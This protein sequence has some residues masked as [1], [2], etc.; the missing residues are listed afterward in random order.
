MVFTNTRPDSVE[1]NEEGGQ[2]HNFL[3]FDTAEDMVR[4][5]APIFAGLTDPGRQTAVVNLD[6]ESLRCLFE[7]VCFICTQYT[8]GLRM[9]AERCTSTCRGSQHC[10]AHHLFVFVKGVTVIYRKF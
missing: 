10:N 5:H 2:D 7:R 9:N 4:A 1:M 3:H 8:R 6:G